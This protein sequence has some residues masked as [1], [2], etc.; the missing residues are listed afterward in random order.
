[1][2]DLILTAG[3]VIPTERSDEGPQF[4]SRACHPDRATLYVI[5]TE[6]LSMSSRQS[7]ATRDLL[8]VLP[9]GWLPIDPEHTLGIGPMSTIIFS[10]RTTR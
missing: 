8:L 4:N 9:T 5:P 1:M 3:L 10:V 2:R 6:Q 7:A